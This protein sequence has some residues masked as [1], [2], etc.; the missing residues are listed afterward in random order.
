[1]YITCSNSGA[2]NIT[3][4]ASASNYTSIVWTSS[5]N[6]TFT[7]AN[8]INNC[9]YTP[10]ASDISAGSVILTLTAKAN[11]PCSDVISTKTLTITAAPGAN[12]GTP[13]T[14][15]SNSGPVNI[16]AG[17][18]ATNGNGISW[19]SS[20]TGSFTNRTSISLCT[21]LPSTADKSAGSVTLTLTVTG[22]APCSNAVSTK[23]LTITAAPTA[24]AGL[25]MA[26]CYSG[27]E[28]LIASGSTA[29]GYSSILWTSSG[30]GTFTNA[31]SL[32]LCAY[33][34]SEADI[35]AGDV[36]LTLTA[37]GNSPCAN[38]ISTKTLSITPAPVSVAGPDIFTCSNSG[39][40]NITNGSDAS[41][42]TTVTWTSAGTGT[43][44]NEHSLTDCTYTPSAADIT[45]GSV[46]ISLTA[47]DDVLCSDVT[48][49][50]TLHI[51][52]SPTAS[53]TGSHAICVNTAYTLA[54][55]E[56][57]A[58]NYTTLAWT[59][60]GAG[61]ITSGA[62]SLTPTYTPAPG[63]AGRTVTLTLTA[64]KSPCADAIAT[65]LI[66]C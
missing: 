48:S 41:N 13:V 59:E 30:T 1:M 29:T 37:I 65:Y 40:I 38:A 64:S 18:I 5:G 33:T 24:Y 46:L 51:T 16:T 56:A 26:T 45:A 23:A 66:T 49:S 11:L 17:A 53:T 63:D 12:A 57:T 14:T 34:P 32:S 54:G 15:C 44:T 9:T 58:A 52:S 27:G 47:Y 36:V 6:G 2:V 3:T 50:K 43:F 39:A 7:N 42:Y 55:G 8:S 35:F 20:G 4:G 62:N 25:A 10:S 60:N 28:I 31:G 21:Y 19:S 22:N 61:S